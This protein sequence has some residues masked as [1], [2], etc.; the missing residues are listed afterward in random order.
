[1][2]RIGELLHY[3]RAQLARVRDRR[4]FKAHLRKSDVFLVGHPKSGNTWLTYMLALCLHEKPDEINLKNL[5]SF[6]P[7]IHGADARIAEFDR[8]RD[9]RFFRNEYPN[10][11][12]Y[13]P[14]TIYIVRDPRSVMVSSYHHSNAVCAGPTPPLDVFVEKYLE[15]GCIAG[16]GE[17]QGRWDLQVKDWL[18][19]SRRQAVMIVKYEDILKNREA[20]L[21]EVCAFLNISPTRQN[22]ELAIQSGSFESMREDEK[23]HGA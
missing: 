16:F 12:D 3:P 15:T 19:R 4:I 9:P 2:D 23:L 10:F 14:K 21:I 6:S 5:S 17:G 1:M 20:V 11:P 8:L 7:H 18:K 13:Y 22:L